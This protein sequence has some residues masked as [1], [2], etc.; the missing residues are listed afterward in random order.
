M[1]GGDSVADPTIERAITGVMLRR[2][3]DQ[4]E[5]LD[6]GTLEFESEQARLST[7]RAACE[8]ERAR[9]LAD[10]YPN[11]LALRFELGEVFFRQGLLTEAI[12]EFQKA[13]ANPHRRVQALFYLGQCFARR[14]IHDLALRTLQNALREKAVFDE[15]KKAILYTLGEVYE[16]MGKRAD[17]IEQYK[18]IYEAD[19]GFRDVAA[20]VDAYYSAQQQQ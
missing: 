5:A 1:R 4:L 16:Q 15:E 8:L 6:S 2:I 20:K 19:I 7:A 10:Q 13:Q 17:A 14:R 12:Q 11:D 18:L 9:R 3:D